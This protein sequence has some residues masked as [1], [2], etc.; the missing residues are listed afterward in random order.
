MACD[1]TIHILF[2]LKVRVYR[3]HYCMVII[4]LIT[5]SFQSKIIIINN[6]NRAGKGAP[7][8]I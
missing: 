7:N 1:L 2:H 5:Y 6:N 3:D 8:Y 4:I